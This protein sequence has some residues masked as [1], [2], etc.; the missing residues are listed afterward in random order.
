M[1]ITFTKNKWQKFTPTEAYLAKVKPIDTLQKLYV[2]IQGFTRLNDVKD[3][4]QTPEQTLKLKTYDCEDMAIFCQDI[5]VRMGIDAVVAM[6]KG[7]G[8]I[9]HAVCVFPYAGQYSFFSNKRRYNGYTDYI[10]IGHH[11]Y[12]E[13]KR[14][15]IYDNKGKIIQKKVS[16]FGT[17]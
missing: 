16:L 10:Q 9:G 6:Y 15:Y 4:W 7:T 3:Y 5:L 8:K 2:F 13:L 14:M 1:C 17:F 11:Y 12:P